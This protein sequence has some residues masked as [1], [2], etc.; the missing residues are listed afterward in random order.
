MVGLSF[1]GYSNI[2]NGRRSP[3]INLLIALADLFNVSVDMLIGRTTPDDTEAE[4]IKQ[5]YISSDDTT[6][7]I[8]RD[9]LHVQER[10]QRE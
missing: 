8:V 4:D 9:I 3:D 7:R 10:V 6:R 2:E 5:V 1:S